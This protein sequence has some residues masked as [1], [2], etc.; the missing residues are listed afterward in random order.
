MVWAFRTLEA[1]E[2]RARGFGGDVVR[3]AGLGTKGSERAVEKVWI[4]VL[5]DFIVMTRAS[6]GSFLEGDA[7]VS[8]FICGWSF[9]IQKLRYVSIYSALT[10]CLGLRA[11]SALDPSTRAR[12]A[13]PRN[14]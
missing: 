7:M 13:Q 6:R 14:F 2:R 8:V 10:A 3:V 11:R 9:W 1:E 4:S 12:Q 5:R